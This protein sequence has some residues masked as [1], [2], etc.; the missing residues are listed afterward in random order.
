M[1]GYPILVQS[2]LMAN[3]KK[4]A[5]KLWNLSEELTGIKY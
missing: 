3:S 2:N 4:N 5:I 1:R